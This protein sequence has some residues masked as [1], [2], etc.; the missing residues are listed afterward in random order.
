MII[1]DVTGTSFGTTTMYLGC[2]SKNHAT[3]RLGL[4]SGRVKDRE[5][6]QIKGC[7]K[8]E[9]TNEEKTK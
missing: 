1:S 7:M 4:S 8:D 2:A 6:A 5:R 9:T 3:Q